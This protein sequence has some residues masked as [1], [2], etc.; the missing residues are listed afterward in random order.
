MSQLVTLFPAVP[1][2]LEETV[3]HL[4]GVPETFP[5]G[6]CEQDLPCK[7]TY[8]ESEK[9]ESVAVSRNSW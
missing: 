2:E 5:Y 9:P 6:L 3:H 7:V 8:T 1:V 4:K